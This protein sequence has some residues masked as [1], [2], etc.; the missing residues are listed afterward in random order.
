MSELSEHLRRIQDV[1]AA[2]PFAAR[3]PRR[4]RVSL[5]VAAIASTIALTTAASWTRLSPLR[6]SSDRSTLRPPSGRLERSSLAAYRAVT[7]AS[8]LYRA[9]RWEAALDAAKRAADLDPEY[10]EAWAILGKIYARLASPAGLPAGGSRDD[11]RANALVSAR[12]AVDLDASSYEGHVALALAHRNLSQIEPSRTAARQAIALGPKFSEAYGVLGDTYS[13]NSGYGCGHDRDNDLAISLQRQAQSLGA[14]QGDGSPMINLLKYD[15]RYDEALRIADDLLR[16]NP[17]SRRIRRPRAWILMELGRLDEA[18]RM[19]QE[20]A[21]DGGIRGNDRLY[22]AG[23]ALKRGHLEVA[24]EGFEKFAPNPRGRIEIARQYIE[25]KVPGPA[26]VHLERGLRA[27]PECA[28]WM[29]NTKASYWSVIRSL[30]AARALL[31]K[32]TVR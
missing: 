15:K 2:I 23:I 9:G 24:A 8:G 7:E 21:A 20:A 27:E 6:E 14:S 25:A 3:S 17:T 26:L 10:A 5:I 1:D 12:R 22:L 30:P 18:E 31:E 16:K 4:L 28:R 11:Y 19:L 29:L 32:Y 13:E